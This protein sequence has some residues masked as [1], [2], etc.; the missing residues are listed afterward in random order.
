MEVM[1]RALKG[2]HVSIR[3]M[4]N[5]LDLAVDDLAQVFAAHGIEQAV[6]L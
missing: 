2:G 3:R 5:L 1:A 4:A 6:A